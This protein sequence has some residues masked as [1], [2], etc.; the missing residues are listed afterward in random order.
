MTGET[1]DD[2]DLGKW[3][4]MIVR[5][6]KVSL[7]QAAE[8]IIRTDDWLPSSNDRGWV[9]IV[10]ECLGISGILDTDADDIKPWGRHLDLWR[11]KREEAGCLPVDYLRTTRIASCYIGGPRGWCDWEGNIASRYCI[12][13]WP[14]V[15]LVANEWSLIAKAFP[16]LSL[17]CQLY[18][19]DSIYQDTGVDYELMPRV[20]I[21]P[22]VEFVLSDGHVHTIPSP[23]DRI[24][25]PESENIMTAMAERT[26]LSEH[27][28][29]IE[30]LQWAVSLVR[31]K[32]RRARQ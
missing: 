9:R 32:M 3:P 17:R 5:G 18:H 14:S 11:C 31:D 1:Q 13:K 10:E 15:A 30:T 24:P 12:G 27:G 19:A 29:A 26:Y 16:Y 21:T 25:L 6:K 28:C 23:T 22:V 4:L 8:I 20:G 7:E 2:L